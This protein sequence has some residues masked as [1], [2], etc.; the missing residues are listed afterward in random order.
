MS[1]EIKEDMLTPAFAAQFAATLDREV[2]DAE[3]PQGIHWCLT[4]PDTATGDL[5][6]DGHPEK[7]AFLPTIAQPRRMWGCWDN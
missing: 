6:F 4:T 7:I 2:F 5:R 3:A 1:V